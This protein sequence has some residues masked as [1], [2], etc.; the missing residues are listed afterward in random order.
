[1]RPLF[2]NGA[3]RARAQ[4]WG[5]WLLFAGACCAARAAWP[6][7]GVPASALWWAVLIGGSA[8]L[9]IRLRPRKIPVLNYHSV[10]SRPDWL[11]IGPHVSITPEAFER[12]LRYLRQEG[13]R[14]LFVSEVRDAL[15][16]R[17]EAARC[18]ALTFDDGY[19]DNWIAAFPLLKKYGM[20]ATL[21][22]STGFIEEADSCRPTIEH[23]PDSTG[24]TLDWTGYLTWP[25]IKAMQA[26][27]LV[28]VQSHGRDHTRVFS[29]PQLRGFVGPRKPNLWLLW[30]NRPE[31]RA[32]WWREPNTDRSLW[33]HPVFAQAPALAQRAYR[34]DEEAVKDT[35]FWA[36]RE[37]SSV[38]EK[39]DW[40]ERV[41]DWW[42]TRV[43]RYGHRDTLES[44][45]EYKRRV[46]ED[47]G[48][49]RR[50]LEEKL[51]TKVDTLCWPEN[52]FTDAG[53][54]A[55]RRLGHQATVSNRHRSRNAVGEA[56]DRIVRVFIGSHALGIAHPFWDFASFVLELKV[57]E[58]WYVMYPLLAV[59][60]LAKKCAF[61]ARSRCSCRRDYLSI[62]S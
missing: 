50:I 58:G 1:M 38:F 35:L 10:S 39:P 51:G 4:A 57:F 23:Q 9:L 60:H 45:E 46:E 56:P 42:N 52:A 24:K 16:G 54:A 11:Q 34:P 47:T 59:M 53:E 25:E 6:P 33:G 44:E 17:A 20:K 40:E 3:T 55:V 13:Y 61:A 14:S 18:V 31:T 29:A 28:E 32:R 36:Q 2:D 27:G 62:W 37:G 26:S 15:A 22:V 30:N 5:E 48:E 41:Y 49:A 7:G 12:Q 43:G 8:L 19:A 21:F